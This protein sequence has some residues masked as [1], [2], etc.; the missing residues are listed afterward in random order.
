MPGM[1]GLTLQECLRDADSTLP[2]IFITGHGD[3][4][5]AA[6]AL[7]GG[8]VAFIQKPFGEEQLLG[9]VGRALALHERR[10]TV[11]TREDDARRGSLT[12]RDAELLAMVTAQRGCCGVADVRGV[13]SAD[14]DLHCLRLMR[15]LAVESLV[16]LRA[17]GVNHYGSELGVDR[18]AVTRRVAGVREP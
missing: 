18:S 3:L 6:H 15:R 7:K 12:P 13:D 10:E 16:G 2:V 17:S 8:A 14:V 4:P 9:A 1:S 11:R 5:D